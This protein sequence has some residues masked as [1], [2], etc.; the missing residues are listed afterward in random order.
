[1]TYGIDE[2]AARKVIDLLQDRLHAANDLHLTLKHVHWNVVGPNFIAVHEMLDPH[3]DEVRAMAD[4]LA[5]RIATL[6]GAPIGTPAALVSARTWQD[7]DLGRADTQQHLAA[8]DEVY[9]GVV[10]SFRETIDALGDL[11][12]VSQDMVIGE[13]AVLEKFHW[14]VR[15]HMGTATS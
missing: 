5:E 3:T 9:Q 11:D 6:G 12:P 10:K 4:E 1:M 8:L 13:S 15:A 14:F 2:G 7:Y